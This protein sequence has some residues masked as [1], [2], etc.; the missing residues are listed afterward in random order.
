MEAFAI[1]DAIADIW[2]VVDALNGYITVQ[3]PWMLAKDEGQRDR[4]ATVLAVVTEGLRAIAQLV[5]PVIPN[6]AEKL[7]RG[8]GA[9]GALGPLEQQPLREAGQWGRLPEGTPQEELAVLFPRI[10]QE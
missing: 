6:A 4:L 9:H 2:Q 8:L 5:S 3:E 7:W 1:H 10:E